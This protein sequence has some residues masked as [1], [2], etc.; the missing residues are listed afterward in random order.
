MEWTTEHVFT[1]PDCLGVV[2]A[3]PLQRA[4]A[5][6]I[7]GRAIG[8]L[9]DRPEVRRA[10][11]GEKPPEG[12]T[13]HIICIVA[14]IWSGKTLFAAAKAIVSSQ[15]VDV[16]GLLPSD[17]VRI[18]VLATG[19]DQA[20]QGYRH[21]VGNLLLRPEL[22]RIVDPSIDPTAESIYVRHPTGRPIEI[23]ISAM[24][25]AG[26]TLISRRLPCVIFDEATR[27]QGEDDGAVKN[28][29]D[30]LDA[31]EGRILPGGCILIIGSPHAP[32]GPVY[33]LVSKRFGKPDGD[34][35]VIRAR[36][37]D[38]NPTRWTPERCAELKRRNPRAYRTDVEAEFTDESGALLPSAH[39]ERAMRT[40]P[41]FLEPV[42]GH[43][44]VAT[45]DP[46]GRA[47]AWTFLI[48]E[49]LDH[50]F[51]VAV[52]RQYIKDIQGAFDAGVV[53][54]DVALHCKR[55]GIT[56]VWSDQYGIEATSALA[57]ARGLS[58]L[59]HDWS[60]ENR[61]KAAQLM[62]TALE[63]REL[64]LP[65]NEDLRE[66]LVRV[67]KKATQNGVTIVLKGG[68]RH[69]DFFPVLGLA[70][71]YPPEPPDAA[72]PEAKRKEDDPFLAQHLETLNRDAYEQAAEGLG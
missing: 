31:I 37:P 41:E 52:A 30:S 1:S 35:L 34:C 6:A 24:S 26:T 68:K 56:D 17:E 23:T 9:W 43:N 40:T 19:K 15:L 55:F 20:V 63:D 21:I 7:D 48:L 38:M 36:G 18:P 13:P 50:G 49:A 67:R 3:T 25:R 54:D 33:K 46:G 11:G 72:L 45:M 32:L 62:Q 58:V 69:C 53:M 4:I 5:R 47:S 39:I 60:L 42:P 10:F 71:L 16:R 14:G 12:V 27:V 64:E 57:D 65:P 51:R 28:L 22:N 8:D 44:Y 29:D 70:L 66:D 59:V 2:T 61:W